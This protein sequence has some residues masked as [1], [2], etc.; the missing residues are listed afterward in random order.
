[1]DALEGVPGMNTPEC[2][3]SVVCPDAPGAP[4]RRV[5]QVFHI[6]QTPV[7]DRSS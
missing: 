7:A 2:L 6:D 4:R 1:M 3:S 5:G